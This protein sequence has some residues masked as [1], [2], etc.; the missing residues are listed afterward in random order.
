[1]T[2]AARRQL[3]P[4]SRTPRT[5]EGPVTIAR[6]VR[7]LLVSEAREQDSTISSTS[8][9]GFRLGN[10]QDFQL[11]DDTGLRS[12]KKASM[13]GGHEG[14][15]WWMLRGSVR[16]EES[17]LETLK[18]RYARGQAARGPLV[19]ANEGSIVLLNLLF[20]QS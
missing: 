12:P 2:V 15:G 11:K 20:A 18:R 3:D 9:V 10:R 13:W 19:N 4:A 6:S 8:T 7:A 5:A 17:A 14:M 16:S 1:M